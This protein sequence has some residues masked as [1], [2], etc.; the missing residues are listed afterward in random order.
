MKSGREKILVVDD[1]SAIRWSLSEALRSWGY[2]PAE[3]GTVA[4]AVSAF[5][6]EEPAAV[7]L[8]IDLPDGSGLD[9]LRE[10]K[11][12]RP[13]AVV[14][15]PGALP[16]TQGEM[17]RVYGLPY[18]RLP[19]PRFNSHEWSQVELLVN[20]DTGTARMAVAQPVGTK[21]WEVLDLRGYRKLAAWFVA[22]DY[23]WFKAGSRS[24]NCCRISGAAGSQDYDV[25]YQRVHLDLW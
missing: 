13:E 6:A 22:D 17:D 7:L 5:E 14:I 9:A 15:N 4:A 2:E 1:D 21:A 25:A 8:D 24:I 18:T 19:H 11:G 23:Q 3:A 16:L 12:R 10:I 20:A